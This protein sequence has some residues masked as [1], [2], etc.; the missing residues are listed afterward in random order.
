MAIHPTRVIGPNRCGEDL[1]H[2][3]HSWPEDGELQRCDGGVDPDDLC[4]LCNEPVDPEGEG[5]QAPILWDGLL[6]L[7]HIG[8]MADVQHERGRDR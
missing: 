3:P 1:E 2:S 6:V 8:C 5:M 4:P 7:G